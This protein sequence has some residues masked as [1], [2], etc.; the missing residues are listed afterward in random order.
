MLA[1]FAVSCSLLAA[2]SVPAF[3]EDAAGHHHGE[4]EHVSELGGVRIVHAWTRATEDE[5]ALV[6]FELENGSDKTVTLIGGESEAASAVALVGIDFKGGEAKLVPLP[7]VP[8]KPGS[9]LHLDPESLALQLTGLTAPLKQGDVVEVEVQLDLGHLDVD[10][11]VEAA[12]AK[13]HSH[14]GHSH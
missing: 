2:L 6:F 8:V 11:E 9:E 12:D 7:Q 1:N 10:V 13:G 4:A 14:A 3:S 5:E